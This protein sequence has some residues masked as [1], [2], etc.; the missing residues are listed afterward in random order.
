[1]AATE[2]KNTTDGTPRHA[3][4]AI[5]PPLVFATVII[6]GVVLDLLVPVDLLPA[7][8]QRVAGLPIIGFSVF[9]SALS[10]RSFAKNRTTSSHREKT[11][12]LIMDGPFAYTRNP[13]YLSGLLL[14]LG[15]GILLDGV[16]IVALIVPAALIVHYGAV[17]REEEYLLFR[18]GKLYNRYKTSVRRWI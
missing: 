2:L 17:L 9:L 6:F 4:V 3:R 15:L 7:L 8:A 18:F 11:T 13:L 14:D 16:W 10:F 1:M 5:P 12:A